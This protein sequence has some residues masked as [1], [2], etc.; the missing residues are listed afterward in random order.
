[1]ENNNFSHKT[2]N[3]ISEDKKNN[4]KYGSKSLGKTT[5][6]TYIVFSI[7]L[8]M[9]TECSD[10]FR[11]YEYINYKKLKRPDY[12]VK[13]CSTVVNK[14]DIDPSTLEIIN[15]YLILAESR[16]DKR[17]KIID[18]KSNELLKSFGGKGQGPDEFIGV[19]QIIPDQKDNNIF[20]I[21]DISTRNLKK[22]NIHNVLNNDSYPE[23][24]IRL[25]SEKSGIPSQLIFTPDNKILAVGLFF[26]GRISI[27]DMRGGYIRSIGK[28]PVT[29]KNERFAAQ[30]SH[31]FIG[32]FIFKEKSKEIFIATR[33]GSIV[34]KY[35]IDGNLIS[36]FH[37]PDSFFPEYEIVPA[38]EYYT[39]T[40]NNKS[41]FGYLDIRY[42]KELDR[43][44]LL[45]SGKYRYN[46]ENS[47]ANFGN[48]IYVLDNKDKIS[49]QIELDKE[50]FQMNISDDGSTIF[51]LSETEILK[52][53]YNKKLR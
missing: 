30:H 40:Y 16:S 3:N 41:R 19:S 11:K 18:S 2:V 31:G 44:F 9:F 47:E 39:M 1:M 27:Y 53:E 20:W 15:N 51:G 21:Y 37:G 46:K 10:K 48:T 34:E 5:T 52:F 24:I 50:I 42:N 36:T 32:Q 4:S 13:L 33:L 29:L 28:I 23:E 38:G 17:I 12:T 8:F 7:F 14:F 6:I 49:E 35:S 45:Y 26:K 43:I 25:P 22:F